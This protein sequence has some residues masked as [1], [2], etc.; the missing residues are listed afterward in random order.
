MAD[1]EGDRGA[2]STQ[3]DELGDQLSELRSKVEQLAQD[4]RAR[5]DPFLDQA[6]SD[7]ESARKAAE[8]TG[9]ATRDAL[10]TASQEAEADITDLRANLA[11]VRADLRTEV[12]ESRDSYL[13]ALRDLV[14]SWR[15]RID[16]LR[17]QADLGRMDARDE[18]QADVERAEHQWDEL[19]AKADQFGDQATEATADLRADVR[20]LVDDL[21]ETLRK[22]AD[23]LAAELAAENDDEDD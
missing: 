18:A 22:V 12:A 14:S 19:K 1:D 9:S 2:L 11:T 21:R 16:E 3:I 10:R 23:R 4:A 8:R 15:A 13:D 17:V 6:R 20:R 5:L 7:W